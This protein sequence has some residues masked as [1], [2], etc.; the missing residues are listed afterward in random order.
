MKQNTKTSLKVGASVTAALLVS[1][2]VYEGFSNT[3]IPVIENNY[4]KQWCS[5]ITGVPK[6]D[7]YTD[8]DCDR[9]TSGHLYRDLT[10]LDRC[11][12]LSAMPERIQ[13]SARHIAYNISPGKVC[14]STMAK[15]WRAGDYTARSCYT[16]LKYT[17][18][19]GQDCRKTGKR[20]PGIV[21]RRDYEYGTCTGEI[22]WRVQ[23]WEY[24]G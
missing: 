5:G 12:N 11:M 19:A 13:F 2:A 15:Y 20:C 1:I 23:A 4:H 9:L 3:P 22:D 6:Q 7:Y 24:K 21:T 18:V 17:F 14:S 16:I 10:V 8:E